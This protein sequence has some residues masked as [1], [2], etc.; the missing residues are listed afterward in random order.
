MLLAVLAFGLISQIID[1][2][3]HKIQIFKEKRCCK[4]HGKLNIITV[5]CIDRVH[6]IDCHRC[7]FCGIT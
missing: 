5:K 7:L 4:C 6:R 2:T 3:A 1:R